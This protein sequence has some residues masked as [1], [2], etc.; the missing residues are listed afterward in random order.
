MYVLSAQKSLT[1]PATQH[2]TNNNA[3]K[4][5]SARQHLLDTL[6]PNFNDKPYL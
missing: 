3:L 4:G 6:S 1:T 2:T 5:N